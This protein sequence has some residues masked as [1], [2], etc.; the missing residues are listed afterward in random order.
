MGSCEETKISAVICD[1]DGTLL[2]SEMATKGIV[3]EF[4]GKYGKVMR[5]D[6]ENGRLGKTQKESAI[7]IVRDYELPLSPEQFI[8]EITPLFKAKWAVAKALP[9]GERLIKHLHKH[10]VPL[11]L[12]SNSLREYI[13]AKI[14]HHDGWE[15]CFSVILGSDQVKSGKPAPDL[16]LEAARRLGVDAADCLVIED[17][18]VGVKAAKAA[19]MRVL[20]VP[21]LSEADAAS[22]ADAV[23]HSLLDFQ[24]EYWGL[25]PF[26]DGNYGVESGLSQEES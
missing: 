26:D 20:A 19:G 5:T 15:E 13:D 11:A 17:S 10:Q 18:L 21:S 16:F 9:G 25:P 8:E 23:H 1:L 3:E 24:P 12:A 7:A 4:L 22:L 2:N 6:G 14:S